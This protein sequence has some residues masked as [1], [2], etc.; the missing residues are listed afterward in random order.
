VSSILVRDIL[1]RVGARSLARYGTIARRTWPG[2]RGGELWK[3]TWTRPDAATVATSVGADAVVR[4]AL[5][6]YP[7]LDYINLG[8]GFKPYILA[9][10][11]ATPIVLWNR[12]LTQAAWVKTNCTPAKDQLGADAILNSASSLVATAANATCLQAIT[13]ASSL[14]TQTAYIKRLVGSGEIDMTMDGGTTWTNITGQLLTTGYVRIGIPNQTLANPSVGFR[15]VTNGDKI[16]VDFVQNE[17]GPFATSAIGT[18]GTVT[19]RAV[20]AWSVPAPFGVQDMTVYA[21]FD[22][23][24]ARNFASASIP[25]YRLFDIGMSANVGT[26]LYMGNDGGVSGGGNMIIVTVAGGVFQLFSLPLP[27]S[28]LAEFTVQYRAVDGAINVAVGSG[29]FGGFSPSPGTPAKSWTTP[30]LGVPSANPGA[31]RTRDIIGV[32]GLRSYAEMVAIP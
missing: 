28:G 22:T 12:D 5:A 24:F 8:D 19:G 32:R 18:V 11:A 29:A 4:G 25:Y 16:A 13:L 2:D 21:A 1:F 7:R 20:D 6:N 10:P 3:E 26:D 15:I 9:E 17:A 14:R 23:L 30:L 31:F 27:S